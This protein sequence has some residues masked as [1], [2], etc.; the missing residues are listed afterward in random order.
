[1]DNQLL[2][3]RYR[4]QK[5]IGQGGMGTVY[6]ATDEYLQRQVAVKLLT[7][8]GLGSQGRDRLLQE[9]RAVAQLNHPHIV[10]VFDA[11]EIQADNPSGSPTPFIVMEYV[12][13]HT[14]ND[15]ARTTLPAILQIAVQLC[16]ALDHAHK[17]GIIHRDIKPE[18]I[19]ITPEGSAKLMDFGLARSVASR[20]SQE[21]AFVGTVFYI[22]PE[23]ALGREIDTRAD[24]YAL[25]VLLYELTTR[26]LPFSADDPFAI[27]T[28]HLHAPPVPPIARNPEIPGALN[29]LILS[30][31]AKEPADRPASAADV[32]ASLQAMIPPSGAG[33]R[34]EITTQPAEV[35]MLDRIVR[36]RMV[37]RTTELNELRR[38]WQATTAGQ[39]QF[40]LVSGE[41]GIGKSRLVQ[42]LVTQVNIAG[43][44]GFTGECYPEGGAPYSPFAHIFSRLIPGLPDDLDI[45]SFILADI[46]TVAPKLQLAY[47]GVTPN[48]AVA[49]QS[50][51][52]RVMENVVHLC[53][54]LAAEQPLMFVLEDVHWADSGTLSLMRHL[55]R[56]ARSHPIM[57]V[58]TYRESDLDHNL[59]FQ[60]TLLDLSR[61]RLGTRIK[62]TRLD[63]EATRSLLN[64]LFAES[65]SA[66]FVSAIFRETEGNPFFVEEVIKALIEGDLLRFED[67]HWVRP[68][69][70]DLQIPQSIRIAIQQRITR[71]P[72]AAQDVLNASAV[73]G[74]DFDFDTLAELAGADEDTLIDALEQ[75]EH[76]QLIEETG[77]QHGGTFRFV[78][79][80]I[81]STVVEGLSGLRKRRLHRHV[82]AAIQK[83]SPDD[84]EKLAHH[85]YES[86]DLRTSLDYS[87]QA[88]E[89]ARKLFASEEAR[90]HYQRALEI[91]EALGDQ[92][93]ALD[94]S[95]TLAD[96]FEM[97]GRSLAAAELLEHMLELT[98]DPTIK[99]EIVI[100]IC[101]N[102]TIIADPRALAY[103]ETGYG[104]LTPETD[105]V[106]KAHLLT[107]EARN[108]HYQAHH[109]DAIR[110]LDEAL[111]IA[112]PRNDKDLLTS[113]Y[114]TLAGNY[115]HLAQMKASMYWAGRLM[116][117]GDKTD[118][119]LITAIGMEF[120]AEGSSLSGD[121]HEARRYSQI[122]YDLGKKSGALDRMAWALFGKGFA[123][124]L[125]G[126]FR[127]ALSYLDEAFELVE[128]I[129][130][131][132]LKIWLVG[133]RS[134]CL[135]QLGNLAE[136]EK[137]AALCR[138][139]AED[140]DQSI[141]ITY[142]LYAEGLIHNT[143]E[144]WEASRELF[145]TGLA[146][147]S[148]GD[149]MQAF[150]ACHEFGLDALIEL[151]LLDQ[152]REHLED[153]QQR[154]TGFEEAN[155]RIQHAFFSGRLLQASGELAEAAQ[156][157]RQALDILAEYPSDLYS[158]R[159]HY[160]LGHLFAEQGQKDQA[161]AAW[162]QAQEIF[163]RC[164]TPYWLGKVETALDSL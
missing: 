54:I 149:N 48:A 89:R 16:E 93:L 25:G 79:A 88:G 132:R 38:A 21:G 27:I 127:E 161:R 113:L 163:T 58:A 74:R 143:R 85:A 109:Q 10:T 7:S 26:Q 29:Q 64:A 95:I 35:G 24:L 37:G 23:Q 59:P 107:L 131:N 108:A 124:T 14:L 146:R 72:P 104:M 101:R 120:A 34:P 22:A 11:G 42:E 139:L 141:L 157:Y 28:Q 91:A 82:V 99:L 67:G 135:G 111:V 136:A 62:L 152:A 39:G 40:I 2:N 71:L 36:G 118:D 156:E 31:L 3:N 129:R 9:A 160:Q 121:Y 94:L 84:L 137:Q 147:Q 112:E 18:N 125:L 73:L 130:E 162:S 12:D 44:R 154:I 105:P 123:T 86:G 75:M 144:E 49:S 6:L 148:K 63:Q 8:S 100:Q 102:F 155:T 69:L 110:A 70:E 1:M 19:L 20:L 150:L 52:F 158:A 138:Q 81:P 106:Y 134:I 45:P 33:I 140:L 151:G 17:K 153:F 96:V 68:A 122:N 97:S 15:P 57:L 51:Q 47:P 128:I 66:D 13:G 65:T 126:Q 41:P 90:L 77:T 114:A 92:P 117:L 30:L 43:P 61:E 56:A 5:P 78:H 145:E 60:N 4:L 103:L 87:Q 53:Q 142:A 76:A 115:Q 164:E 46:L 116:E 80:L 32:L 83:V 119:P 55:A 50:E 98:E 133:S 159:T